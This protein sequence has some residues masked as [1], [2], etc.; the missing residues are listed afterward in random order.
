MDRKLDSKK[1]MYGHERALKGVEEKGS[2]GFVRG[3]TNADS[4]RM[5]ATAAYWSATR[6]TTWAVRSGD[7]GDEDL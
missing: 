6:G 1:V 2:T 5:F 7:V 4:Y 3:R